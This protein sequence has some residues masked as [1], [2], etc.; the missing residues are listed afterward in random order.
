M[1]EDRSVAAG[2]T[3]RIV[4]FVGLA[5]SGKST[6][7]TALQERTNETILVEPPFF[8]RVRDLPFF[9][10]NLVR[11]LPFLV[12][13]TF[14]SQRDRC[15]TAREVAW[16]VIL[17]GWDRRL[18]AQAR[19]TDK[20]LV[21]DQGPVFMLTVLHLTGPLVLRSSVA[22]RWWAGM[23]DKWGATID[24]VVNLEASEKTLLARVRRR[25][26]WHGLK[27]MSDSE[28]REFM[29]RYRAAYSDVLLLLGSGGNK[30]GTLSLNTE[31]HSVK[32]T[33]DLV[34]RT[35]ILQEASRGL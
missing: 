18:R 19:R 23:A 14:R 7:T 8:R 1:T 30:V 13:I 26:I 28:A 6:L 15:L 17:T 4:E 3:P 2:R 5:G 22:S 21:L 27:G 33:L 11:A 29:S 9:A 25:P 31:R 16:I 12:G 24:L 10:L 32:E 34:S 20:V 35:L